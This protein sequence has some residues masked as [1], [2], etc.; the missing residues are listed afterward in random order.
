[1]TTDTENFIVLSKFYLDYFKS[2][3]QIED[4]INFLMNAF[5]IYIDVIKVVEPPT[6]QSLLKSEILGMAKNVLYDTKTNYLE[7]KYY[8]DLIALLL[9]EDTKDNFAMVLSQAIDF[10]MDTRNSWRV[11]G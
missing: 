3:R 2:S 7:E 11:H 8:E 10:V 9:K 4:K 1:L 5:G 6:E